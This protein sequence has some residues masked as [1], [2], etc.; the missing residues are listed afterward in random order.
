[1]AYDSPGYGYGEK[2]EDGT[3]VLQRMIGELAQ[4]HNVPYVADNARGT[5]FIGTDPRKIN[6]DVIVY[7]TDKA[8]HGPT[9][10]LIIGK[11][12]VMVQIRRALGMHGQRWGTPSSHGKAAYVVMDPGKEALLGIIAALEVLRDHPERK[13]EPVD[14][15]FE[16]VKEE[17]AQLQSEF[18][19][20]LVFTKS[21]NQL[22]VE[23]NYQNT[24]K[25][26]KMGIP[27]FPI[28]DFYSG[29]SLL[30]YGQT[31]IGMSPST[32]YDGNI[33]MAPGMGTMDKDG[34]LLEKPTRYAIKALVRIIE[35]LCK[36]SGVLEEAVFG[37]KLKSVV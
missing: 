24:W 31:A 9:G 20:G 6:A 12:E 3:P 11:E 10:G 7:S 2:D 13:T 22:F 27:I 16:I 29:A 35:I 21:Y 1:M 15:M 30:R 4:R 17:F 28:E 5:P 14:Q 37:K 19:E 36:Y 26:G 8:F 23:I 25:D 34:N 18:V 33:M 32:A